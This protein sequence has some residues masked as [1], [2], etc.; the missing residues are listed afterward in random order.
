MDATANGEITPN[1]CLAL[2]RLLNNHVKLLEATD[3]EQR[4]WLLEKQL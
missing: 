4:L 3:I 2:S 1:E